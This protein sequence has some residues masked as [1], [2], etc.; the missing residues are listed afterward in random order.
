MQRDDGYQVKDLY[1]AAFLFSQGIELKDVERI[2]KVCWFVFVDK[3][4]CERMTTSYWSGR[5][6]GNIKS[7]VDGI[8]SLKDIIFAKT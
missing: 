3:E 7:F 4:T 5:A 6:M 8:R 2:G 1:L